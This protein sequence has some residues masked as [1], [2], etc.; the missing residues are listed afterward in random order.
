MMEVMRNIQAQLTGLTAKMEKIDVIENEVKSMRVL[1]TDLKNENKQLRS[2]VRECEQKLCEMNERNNLLEN[3]LHSLEQHH[4]GWSAR[5]LNIPLKPE[6]EMD[7]YKVRDVV[8]N[9]ALLPILKGAVE[10]KLLPAVPTA[11]QLLEMA[12]VLPGK[13]GQPK[14]VIL[15]FFNRNEREVIFRLKK[16]YAPRLERGSTGGAGGAGGA[17]RRGDGG[18]DG[19]EERSRLAYPMYEDLTRATFQKL[20]AI[21]QDSRVKSCWTVKGQIRFTLHSSVNEIKKVVS[22]LDPLDKILK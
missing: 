12:H 7:N 10:K 17:G 19:E 9:T 2:E 14:P 20:R 13:P 1:L 21:S 15:R 6:E 8:Y 18:G 22:I 4:R 3:R 16:L 5:I 11:E